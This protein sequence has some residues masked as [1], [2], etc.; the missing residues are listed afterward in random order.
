MS[1]QKTTSLSLPTHLVKALARTPNRSLAVTAAFSQAIGNPEAVP[2]ALMA[3]YGRQRPEDEMK[4][5][6]TSYALPEAAVQQGR[7][8]SE[9]FCLSFNEV[10]CLVIEAHM[11]TTHYPT[12]TADV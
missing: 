8:L 6:K 5:V 11:A 7:N 1:K 2:K 4:A 3:R 9:R 12:V 10:A